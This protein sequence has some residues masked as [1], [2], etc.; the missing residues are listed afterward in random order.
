MRLGKISIIALVISFLLPLFVFAPAKS[1]VAGGELEL[2]FAE[3]NTPVV[4]NV[5]RFGG[6]AANTGDVSLI[7]LGVRI[8]LSPA[9]NSRLTLNNELK[10]PGL[11][12]LMRDTGLRIDVGD[13]A[14]DQRTLWS[15]A[16]LVEQLLADG[17]GVYLVG[18]QFESDSTAIDFKKVAVPF[19]SSLENE[20]TPVGISLVWPVASEEKTDWQGNL[21][22]ETLPESLISTG[23]LANILRAGQGNQVTWVVDP[24]LVEFLVEAGDGYLLKNDSGELVPGQ[25]SEEVNLFLNSLQFSTQTTQRWA[26]PFANSDI[27]ALIR[28]EANSAFEQVVSIAEPILQEGLGSGIAGVVTISSNGS[29]PPEVIG[30]S[31]AAGVNVSIVSDVKYPPIAGTLFTP[32]GLVEVNTNLGREKIL[33]NDSFLS[34]TFNTKVN[35]AEET[36]FFRQ[37]LLSDTFLLSKQVNDPDRVIVVSPEVYWEPTLESSLVIAQTLTRAPWIRPVLLSEVANQEVSNVLRNPYEFSAVD[38]AQELPVEHV[39]EIKRAQGL[40]AQVASI[41]TDQEPVD[42]YAKAIL[43]SSSNSFRANRRDRETYLDLIINSL[44]DTR[45]SVQILAQGSVVLPGNEGSIP[46]TIA[47][48]LDQNVLVR[49]SAKSNPELRFS[50]N[51]LGLIEIEPGAKRGVTL[52]AKI[53]GSGEIDVELQLLTPAGEKFGDPVLISVQSA[54]YSQVATWVAAIAFVALILFSVNSFVRRRKEN[55]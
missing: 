12:E 16:Y 21:S 9:I 14:S 1:V 10:N 31:Y 54:A 22:N 52:E 34:D 41:L 47:N 32:S 3:P 4:G 48:D 37:Q 49:L 38:L 51:D 44:V 7:N 20:I 28:E 29:T 45:S 50:V 35:S 36:V 23:R 11:T 24:A 39:V 46:L 2:N 43:Q 17:D 53:V 55:V 42:N 13:L 27:S 8:F 40:L 30:D 18:F 26:L 5:I 19:R 25:Y 15:T 6:I 33:L